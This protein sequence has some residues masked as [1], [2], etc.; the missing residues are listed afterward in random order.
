MKELNNNELMNVEGGALNA[1]ILNAFARTV[2]IFLELGR[3][4]G[5]AIRRAVTKTTCPVA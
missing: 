5:S 2:S 1:S 4:L 3:S